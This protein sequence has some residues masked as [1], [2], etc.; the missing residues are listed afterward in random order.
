MKK[1][2]L[3]SILFLMLCL[4]AI[5]QEIPKLKS[6]PDSLNELSMSEKWKKDSIKIFSYDIPELSKD[7][8]PLKMQPP[9]DMEKFK[10]YSQAYPKTSVHKL[11]VVTPPE[12]N[13]SLIVVVPD[14][15]V[16]FHLRNGRIK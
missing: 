10:Q 7:S 12:G 9:I 8:I 11:P 16:H 5:S 4:P 6:K 1:H 15:T 3:G 14:T 13:Y 2:L